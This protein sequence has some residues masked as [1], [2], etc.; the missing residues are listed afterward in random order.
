MKT[1]EILLRL[2]DGLLTAIKLR[3]AQNE[4]NELAQNPANWFA[5]HFGYGVQS[6]KH[7]TDKTISSDNPTE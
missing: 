4:R 1:L 2:I 3:K 5:T 7:Q 6:D